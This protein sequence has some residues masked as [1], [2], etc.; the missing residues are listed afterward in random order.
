MSGRGFE[1]E[2]APGA[3]GIPS[4]STL[5]MAP[6][7]VLYVAR[8]G[9]RYTGGEVDDLWPI[10]RIPLGG[11]RMIGIDYSYRDHGDLNN[12]QVISVEVAF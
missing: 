1:R 8:T 11:A 10:Y 6:D 9:R 3:P 5:A 12:T 4:S 2:R 7:G